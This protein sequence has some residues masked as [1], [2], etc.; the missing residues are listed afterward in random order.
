MSISVII[1]CY[2]GSTM[3]VEAV[4]SV[5]AQTLMPTEVIVVN[6]GST[7]DTESHLAMFSAPVRVV[8]QVN[9]GVAAARNSGVKC[10]KGLYIAFL[11]ADDVW[12]PEKLQ[13]QYDVLVA[14]PHIDLLGTRVYSWPIDH[15]PEITNKSGRLRSVALDELVIRNMFTTSSVIIRRRLLDQVGDFDIH[16]FGTEDYDLWL[17]CVQS[18]CSAVL[19]LPLTGY[20]D[21]TPGSLS[22]NALRMEAGVRII[23]S[24]I[25]E[26]TAFKGRPWLKNKAFAYHRYT[27]A[28][29]HYQASGF[30]KSLI[31][32][33]WSLAIY[34]F[35]YNREE[36][37]Y[38][39]GRI[40]LGFE[41]FIRL[42]GFG[43]GS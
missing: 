32:I 27:W 24:K 1:P 21:S 11:D 23:Q 41:S 2:N 5:L 18:G 14:N 20:R 10:A 28:Y 12:H 13:I 19:E 4:Q 36:V 25:K 6:D 16:Q 33:L 9:Q 37:R 8:H 17:R 35:W 15:H 29:M 40:R 34:P 38:P 26:S 39:L 3:V 42:F 7:D 22:K 31:H 43:G 30:R